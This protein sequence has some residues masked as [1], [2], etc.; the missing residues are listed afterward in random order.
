MAIDV[1]FFRSSSLNAWTYCQEKYFITYNLGFQEPAGYA[2]IKGTITHKVLEV[3]AACKKM[4]QEKKSKKYVY[5]DD[6]IG[7]FP[8]TY[9]TLMSDDFVEKLCVASY[10]HYVT[11]NSHIEFNKEKDYEFCKN[12]VYAAFNYKFDPRTQN[13]FEPEKNFN[14]EIKEDWAKLEDGS[15]LAIKGTMDLIVKE[16]DKTLHLC[17]YKTSAS[18]KNWSTGKIKELDDLY[19]DEQLLLY[20]YA[21]SELYPEYEH[22][23]VSIIFLQAGGPYTMCFEKDKRDEFLSLLKKRYEEIKKSARA[24]PINN[25]RSDFRCTRLCH[26]YKTNWPGTNKPM[27]NYIDDYVKVYGINKAAQDLK[28]DGFDTG[29]YKAPGST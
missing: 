24:L 20:Y 28:K 12:M 25:W 1:K 14:I 17:D 29:F 6:E 7:S 26:F 27:C 2:A 4:I 8:F 11:N 21:I 13:I 5:E 18:R 10:N 15:R 22:V 19:H 3:L 16:N 9:Q 23:I